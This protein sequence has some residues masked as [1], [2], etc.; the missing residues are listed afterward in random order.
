MKREKETINRVYMLCQKR[1]IQKIYKIF[2]SWKQRIKN[3]Y[4]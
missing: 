2:N 1:E 3:Q 4:S